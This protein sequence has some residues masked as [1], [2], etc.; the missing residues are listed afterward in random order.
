MYYEIWSYQNHRWQDSADSDLTFS[1]FSSSSMIHAF[2]PYDWTHLLPLPQPNRLVQ[3]IIGSSLHPSTVWVGVF[4][5]CRQEVWSGETAN[6]PASMMALHHPT[7]GTN[8]GSCL[9]CMDANCEGVE[10]KSRLCMRNMPAGCHCIDLWVVL[11]SSCISQPLY[12]WL[13]LHDSSMTVFDALSS[14]LTWHGGSD[15]I[16]QG[17]PL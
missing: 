9:I 4:L 5:I 14:E 2:P 16:H 15:C 11:A 3:Q 17:A 7:R 8:M 1:F 6:I 10:E 13:Y 12:F